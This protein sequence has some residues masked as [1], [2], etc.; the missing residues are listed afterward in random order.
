[1]SRGQLQQRYPDADDVISY[2]I[3]EASE[4]LIIYLNGE[5]VELRV[6]YRNPTE[7]I[8]TW[9]GKPL[10]F[11][12]AWVND[13]LH[14][15]L[16]GSLFIFQRVERQ[17]ERNAVGLASGD[18][19]GIPSGRATAFAQDNRRIFS[20]MA[21]RVLSVSVRP[22]DRISSGDEV[23]VLEAMK[24]E[25]IIRSTLNGVVK[26]IHIEPDRQVSTGDLLVELEDEAEADRAVV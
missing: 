8:C 11:A 3:E 15:W 2:E 12:T 23:C 5:P 7:G 20:G 26:A 4:K 13:D 10:P 17:R 9:R 6:A 14:L 21:G 19:P 25:Q 1:M 16:D 18:A 22:G 24:M